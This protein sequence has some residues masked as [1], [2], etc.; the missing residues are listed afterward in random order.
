MVHQS[1]MEARVAN[2]TVE[3]SHQ[4]HFPFVDASLS[5]FLGPDPFFDHW[6][7]PNPEHLHHAGT[8]C[9]LPLLDSRM[10]NTNYSYKH[11]SPTRQNLFNASLSA[12]YTHFLRLFL[13]SNNFTLYK[14]LE[15]FYHS[16]SFLWRPFLSLI[17]NLD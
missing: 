11:T 12:S 15:A 16:V 17:S 9:P 5:S 6:D 10:L 1:T 8:W 2:V 14:S 4:H 3:I 13:Q 7:K